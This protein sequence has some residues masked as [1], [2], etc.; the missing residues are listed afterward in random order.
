LA[1]IESLDICP[2]CK[3]ALPT[4]DADRHPYLGGSAACWALYGRL[5]AKE[6][7]D[8]AYMRAHRMTV[9]AYAAQH[10]GLPEPRTI[11]SIHVHLVGLYLTLER[12][13]D[14]DFARK[15]IARVTLQKDR[16]HWLTP[17]GSLGGVTVAD[18]MAA[19]TAD[20]HQAAVTRWACAVWE[21]WRSHHDEVIALAKRTL[22]E[23]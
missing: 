8:P 16:L 22:E 23:L 1:N 7:G 13:L 20:D 12:R 5:L 21:A 6:Y 4:V 18:V 17:P 3:A 15:V 9:D 2:D 10:P 19:A 11:Q 14:A